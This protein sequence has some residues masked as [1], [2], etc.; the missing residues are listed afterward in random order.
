MSHD[1]SAPTDVSPARPVPP[2]F[3]ELEEVVRL[4]R[5]LFPGEVRVEF[6]QDPELP[7]ELYVVFNVVAEGDLEDCINRRL[8]WR[9]QVYWLVPAR[10][11]QLKLSVAAAS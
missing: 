4:T 10:A 6:E 5:K 1:V 8:T 7:G 11:D 3:N 9:Q 2:V